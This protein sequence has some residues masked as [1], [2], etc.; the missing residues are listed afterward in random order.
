MAGRKSKASRTRSSARRRNR[1]YG[2]LARFYD[3]IMGDL[4]PAMSRH[5][6]EKILAKE[7]RKIGSVL[8]LACGSGATA[9]DL[10]KKGLDVEA[11][12]LSPGFV[13]QTRRRA[14]AAGVALRVSRGDMRSLPRTVLRRLRARPVDLV[15]CEFSALNN[16]ADRRDLAPV[17]RTAAQAL[18]PG[19]LFLFDI[20][21]AFSFE[22][23]MPATMWEE[24]PGFALVMRGASEPKRLRCSI[25][26]EWFLPAQRGLWRRAH[27]TIHH[28]TWTEAEI[29]RALRAAGF[30]SVKTFDGIDVRPP[31]EGAVRGTDLYFLA[32]R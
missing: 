19:G 3:Q 24:K 11:T 32:R 31:M 28:V 5:A 23:K 25:D 20:D 22:T 30:K 12:D 29:R 1:P 27:E 13:A 18:A 21:T 16:L 8:E 17:I 14:K 9:V 26:F 10:A 4:V 6:R 15:L 2:L 7:W